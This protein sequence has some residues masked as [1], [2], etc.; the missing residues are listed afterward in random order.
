MTQLFF[1]KKIT[2]TFIDNISAIFKNNINN[3][4]LEELEN[5]LIASDVGVS[6]TEEIITKLKQNKHIKNDSDLRKHLALILYDILKPCEKQFNIEKNKP[7]VILIVGVN[8][9]GK[10]TTVGKLAN[11]YKNENKSVIIAAGDTYR[12]AGIEQLEHIC[13]KYNIQLIKQHHQADSASV[14]FDAFNLAQSKKNDLLLADTSGRLHTNN[15]LMKELKKIKTTL[16]KLDHQAP[17]E[18]MMIIDATFGQNII[19]QVKIFNEYL[20]LTGLTISKL[21]GTAKAGIIFNIVNTFK[22]PIR[23]IGIGEKINDIKP[24]NSKDYINNLLEINIYNEKSQND[25][26]C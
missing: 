24:F 18:I 17:H 11:L 4:Y 26:K 19:N 8:G 14:I 6:T 15:T 21:D 5:I 25:K 20:N 12:A 10:T 1:L 9:V 2:N 22:I 23:Y 7:F 3:D 13:T 16:Q